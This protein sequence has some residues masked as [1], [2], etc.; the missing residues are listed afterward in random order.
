M[1]DSLRAAPV[2]LVAALLYD[3]RARTEALQLLGAYRPLL[4]D[5]W[6]RAAQSG[7]RDA[8]L[9]KLAISTWEIALRAAERL[10]PGYFGAAAIRTAHAFMERYPAQGR[11]PADDLTRL[12]GEGP[13]AALAWACAE[14]D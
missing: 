12:L 8:Q 4:P 2:V 10:P 11:M 9:G 7:V 14:L 5:L 13:D 6:R 1:P 3:D